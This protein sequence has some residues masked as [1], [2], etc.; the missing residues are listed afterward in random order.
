MR[1]RPGALSPSSASQ[2]LAPH[3]VHARAQ[4]VDAPFDA[5]NV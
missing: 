5:W 4:S 2:P 1:P 3:A